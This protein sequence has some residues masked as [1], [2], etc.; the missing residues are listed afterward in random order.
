MEG[1]WLAAAVLTPL[2]CNPWGA[3]A[4]EL[5][6]ALLLRGLVLL[7]ALAA[8]IQFIEARGGEPT[9]RRPA[10]PLLWPALA[11]GL[12][13]A[14]AT[15]TSVRPLVSLW[16][17]FE[18]Q[19]GLLT[20][21]A[22]LALYLLTATHLRTRAQADRL[23][24]VLAWGSTPLVIYGL[25]QSTGLDPLAWRTDAA[26]AVLATVGRANTYGTYLVLVIPLTAG[27]LFV[28]RRPWPL[29]L[30]LT[31]QLISVALTQARGAWIGL[32]AGM[33]ACAFAWS[34]DARRKELAAV[35]LGLALLAVSFVALLNVSGGPAARLTRLSGLDR[36]ARLSQTTEG[37]TAARLTIWRATLPLAAARP[38]L[39]YGPETMRTVFARV[40]P[41]QLV[42]YQGRQVAVDRAHNLG[43]D[44]AMSAG[45]AGLIAFLALLAGFTWLAWRGLRG[46]SSHWEAALWAALI[47]VLAGHMVDLQ[48]GFESIASSTIFWLSLALAATSPWPTAAPRTVSPEPGVKRTAWLPYAPL[49]M[50]VLAFIYLL[51]M[52]PL[53][54]DHASWNS[55]Q[56]ARSTEAR[57]SDAERAVHLWPLEPEYR[58]G[59]AEAY[60]QAGRPAAAET[61]LAAADRLSPDD[62]Q[63]WAARGNLYAYWGD[64]EPVHYP[65]AEE[66][67]RHALELAPNV[68]AVHTA[69]GLVLARQGR[70]QEGLAEM[71]RAV[72]LDATDAVAFGHLADL[73]AVLG[74]ED[75]ASRARKEAQRW[76]T[77]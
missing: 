65:Q 56:A 59:L 32:G 55:R 28:A 12:A 33:L 23:W 50:L 62:P 72:A 21:A 35:A 70:L 10:G 51:C 22:V 48:F 60:L 77:Q 18:R 9:A 38:A 4:F 46:A 1:L 71:E 20:L 26:S 67:Y 19:Q 52:R 57:R 41:P 69:M 68:A 37:S 29:A 5:P 76:N 63:I 24:A 43:L 16:G 34:V 44:L 58:A 30:L 74:R 75:D 8:L 66:A 25:L 49:A 31:G 27:R 54:A 36:L 13:F 17:S 39:G 64:R 61:Q 73:Y 40:Y 53:L 11:L 2:A 45:A 42:Y 15:L 3:S 7:I 47:G 6:K 14:L